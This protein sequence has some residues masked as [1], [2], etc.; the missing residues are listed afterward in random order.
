MNLDTR[1]RRAADGVRAS[2][3]GLDPMAQLNELKHEDK[4]RRRATMATAIGSAVV[5]A[6]VGV[7]W[8][9]IQ[10]D[11]SDSAPAI[12]ASTPTPTTSVIALEPGPMIGAGMTPPLV[13]RAPHSWAVWKDGAFVWVDADGSESTQ[14]HIAMSG[15]ILEVFDP[16]LRTGVPIPAEGY[17]EWLRQNPTLEVLDDRMV[18][19]DGQS[20]PQLTVT[21]AADAPGAQFRLG[22]TA[23]D[24]LPREEWP[25]YN[26]EEVV[27]EAVIVVKGETMVVSAVG[28]P[29][30]SAGEDELDEGLA[31]V[32]A[33]M[34]LPS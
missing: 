29:F 16:E 33:T 27:T 31:L 26:D 20:F 34:K 18:V 11:T 6:A 17:A 14:T 8:F 9:A 13:A 32:L 10:S 24:P 12:P 25:D 21:M 22:R 5:V 4:T 1:A 30:D 7:G 19:V 23:N 15:P 3:E 28:S 2:A